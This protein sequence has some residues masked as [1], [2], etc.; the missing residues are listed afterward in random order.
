MSDADDGSLLRRLVRSRA[1]FVA[2]VL[3]V[4]LVAV[5]LVFSATAGLGPGTVAV[6]VAPSPGGRTVLSLPPLGTLGADTHTAPVAVTVELREVDVAAALRTPIPEG[7][8]A[9]DPLPVLTA[10]IREDLGAALVRLGVRLVLV[11][12]LCGGAAALAFPG[13]RSVRRLAAGA[14]LGAGA[15]TLLVAPA[16]LDYDPEALA[17]E[18]RLT[19][20]L[21]AADELVA[22]VGS[23]ETAFGSVDSRARVLSERLA[24]LYSTAVDAEIQRSDGEVV[25]LHV[26][27][28]HLNSV[29]VALTRDL[30]RS[31]DVDAVVDTGDITSFGFAPEAAFTEQLEAVDVPYFLVAGNH[32]SEAVRDRLARSEHLTVLDGDAVDIGGVRVLGVAD[33]TVTALRRVPRDELDATYR[34][35]FDSTRR[36]VEDEDPDLLLVHNPVQARPVLG[37]VPAVAAGHLHRSDLEVVDGTVLAVV[38]SSGATGIGNLLVDD[39]LP[40]SFQL[41]R[42][43]DGALVAV[44]QIELRGVDGDVVLARRVISGDEE[45][46]E[47]PRLT[48]E[49]VDE[50][51]REEM[52]PEDL[53]RA[54]SVPST[55]RPP[56]A[57]DGDG[58][59]GTGADPT[60]STTASTTSTTTPDRQDD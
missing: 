46:S 47:E 30:A 4:T 2:W 58:R 60:T 7:V 29:G 9:D 51:P 17:R 43:V 39:E 57:E 11:A 50:P 10:A 14:A 20:Q 38:G 23:L 12:A 53:D 56:V 59:P 36:L 3:A 41:L 45:G 34:E 16:A 32:D 27:D 54:T 49:R 15:V 44:D 26:S 42:F 40:H 8:D 33:P 13:R 19:G 24:G 6:G 18:P 22:R 31:F 25:L 5:P 1:A 48:E 52:D 35:Q 37:Q 28:L 55:T 21:A